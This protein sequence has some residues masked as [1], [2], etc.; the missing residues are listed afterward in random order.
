[1]IRDQGQWVPGSWLWILWLAGSK[2]PTKSG[3]RLL[4]EHQPR[5]LTTIRACV[6]W[7]TTVCSCQR[8]I[9][10]LESA[11]ASDAG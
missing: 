1:M 4:L 3:T 10:P 9:T 5:P 7:P 6:A 2:M 11:A 8:A